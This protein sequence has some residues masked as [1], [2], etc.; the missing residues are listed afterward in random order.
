MNPFSKTR[1]TP[2]VAQVVAIDPR[3]FRDTKN[4]IS[5]QKHKAKFVFLK[6]AK[7]GKCDVIA[8]Y[9]PLN[10]VEKIKHYKDFKTTTRYLKNAALEHAGSSDRTV[11]AAAEFVLDKHNKNLAKV[12]IDSE[13]ALATLAVA[14]GATHT[15]A[16]I[17]KRTKAIG[18]GPQPHR[19]RLNKLNNK[20]KQ[21]PAPKPEHKP[22]HEPAANKAAVPPLDPSL[23]ERSFA[24]NVTETHRVIDTLGSSVDFAATV[25]KSNLLMDELE[26]LLKD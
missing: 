17:Q 23:Q 14:E 7:N 10:I 25:E 15:T 4:S 16:K 5:D 1:K 2:K 18:Y 13:Q 3:T 20:L 24:E 8:Y 9:R 11:K 26:S 6:P 22:A 12:T 19:T 21:D